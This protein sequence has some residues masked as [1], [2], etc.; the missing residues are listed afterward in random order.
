M[1]AISEAVIIFGG[2]GNVVMVLNGAVPKGEA[3]TFRVGA[4]SVDL[5]AGGH[6]IHTEYGLSAGICDRLK[7]KEEIGL[8]ERVNGSIP[9]SLTGVARRAA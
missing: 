2:T 3:L 6:V 8:L 1:N 7:R 5:V 9:S 4:D